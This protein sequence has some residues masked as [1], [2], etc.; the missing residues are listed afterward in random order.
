MALYIQPNAPKS[1][2]VGV[3]QDRLKI[4][5]QAVPVDGRANAEVVAFLSEIF[6][7]PKSAVEIISG[8]TGRNKFVAITGATISQALQTLSELTVPVTPVVSEQ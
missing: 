4:R 2:V 5:I 8:D 3:Y 1:E 7:V 6:S